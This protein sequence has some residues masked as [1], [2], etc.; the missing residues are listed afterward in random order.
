M[1]IGPRISNNYREKIV[2]RVSKEL[3]LD[4]D[5]TKKYAFAW[6]FKY[7]LKLITNRNINGSIRS[8]KIIKDAAINVPSI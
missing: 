1:E 5:E 7:T 3:I 4:T 2:D 6:E 8:F